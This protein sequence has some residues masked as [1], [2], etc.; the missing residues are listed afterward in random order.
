MPH[1]KEFH[2]NVPDLLPGLTNFQG[3]VAPT[4]AQLI[5]FCFHGAT[6]MNEHSAT[7]YTKLTNWKR[8][9]QIKSSKP[10]A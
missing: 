4:V 8:T 9:L 2:G 10:A 7:N 1:I 5:P 3:S 6:L